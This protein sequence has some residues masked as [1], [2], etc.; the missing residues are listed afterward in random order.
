MTAYSPNL[1]RRG[2]T[3]PLLVFAVL[4]VFTTVA[5]TGCSSNH[6][7]GEYAPAVP[8]TRTFTQGQALVFQRS[9][10]VLQRSGYV[11]TVSDAAAG[12]ITAE[13]YSSLDQADRPQ[14]VQREMTAGEKFLV[15]LSFVLVI[16]FIAMLFAD[17][18][19]DDGGKSGSQEHKEK[20][21]PRHDE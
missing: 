12:V 18:T 16:G 11:L 4:A 5:I 9:I 1:I 17:S 13:R 2:L 20:E 15:F 8:V 14:T 19:K 3:H 7:A 21:H 6:A 10:T